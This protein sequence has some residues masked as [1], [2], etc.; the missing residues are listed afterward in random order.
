MNWCC[1]TRW[2]GSYC[3]KYQF[4]ISLVRNAQQKTIVTTWWI[5]CEAQYYRVCDVSC[6]SKIIII[7]I[8]I[9]M[10][11]IFISG[12]F[13]LIYSSR[14]HPWAKGDLI[15]EIGPRM[16]QNGGMFSNYLTDVQTSLCARYMSSIIAYI[17]S[18]LNCNIDALM[19]TDGQF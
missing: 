17:Y 11:L 5:S 2:I 1:M 3:I 19:A 13:M 12:L 10:I 14:K 16:R 8:I 6:V 7:T 4:G 15:A 18:Y 9:W